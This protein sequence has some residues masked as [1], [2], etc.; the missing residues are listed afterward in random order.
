MD[1]VNRTNR[2]LSF[3]VLEKEVDCDMNMR[4]DNESMTAQN[5]RRLNGRVRRRV[6]L[7]DE[8]R[9]FHSKHSPGAYQQTLEQNNH[10]QQ[11]FRSQ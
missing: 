10:G 5:G 1:T 4:S 6:A 3:D 8:P 9:H 7:K 11:S 2:D